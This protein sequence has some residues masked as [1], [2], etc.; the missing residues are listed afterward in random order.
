[1]KIKFCEQKITQCDP[2]GNSHGCSVR[3]LGVFCPVCA[4]GKSPFLRVGCTVWS[5]LVFVDEFDFVDEHPEGANR[6]VRPFSLVEVDEIFLTH[7]F[8]DVTIWAEY[9]PEIFPGKISA[10][11]IEGPQAV[12]NVGWYQFILLYCSLRS[13]ASLSIQ[14][15]ADFSFF[16]HHNHLLM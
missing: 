5:A 1:L 11:W 13:L 9:H 3:D 10:D 8:R 14:K 16:P 7:L 2:T 4:Q 15:K 12:G 6:L